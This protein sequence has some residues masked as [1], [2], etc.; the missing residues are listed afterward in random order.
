M[1]RR[2]SCSIATAGLM[3][4]I[5]FL[6]WAITSTFKSIEYNRDCGGHLKRAADSNTI[7]TAHKEL[8]HSL[9]YLESHGMTDG[10]TSIMYQTPDE[11]VG[12]W[13]KNLSDSKAE[14]ERAMANKNLSQLEQSNVLMK[15]KETLLDHEQGGPKATEPDGISRY[16]NNTMFAVWGWLSALIGGAGA[17]LV[18]GSTLN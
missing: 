1:N 14:L 17:F 7:P 9:S 5:P 15:L 10:Y 18:V 4:C 6:V 2:G 12:F 11:D 13:Y 16:P 3:L 8:V